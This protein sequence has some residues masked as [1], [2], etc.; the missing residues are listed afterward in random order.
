MQKLSNQLTLGLS[1]KDEAT[2]ANFYAAKNIEI[3]TELKKTA[4]GQGE[5]VIYLCGTRGQG[6]SHLL[7]AACHYAHQQ[8]KTSVYLPLANLAS[9]T[10][11]VLNNLELLDLV[12]IDDLHLIAGC[13]DWEEAVFHLYNRIRDSG[14]KIIVAAKDL[15]KAIQ[16]NLLDLISRLSWGFVFQLH[17]LNDTEKLSIL[18]M[19]AKHRGIS[20]SEEVGKFILT[21]CPR[22]MGTLFAALD[23]L[24]KASLAAQRRLTIPFVKEVLEI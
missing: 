17:P 22:H 20:L 10:P 5:N 2:F 18:T 9:Y 21:H 11:E 15:P 6:C 12:C 16:L 4:S 1:L 19:R 24:D 13:P 8:Q 3:V 7:Q 23:A 14:K